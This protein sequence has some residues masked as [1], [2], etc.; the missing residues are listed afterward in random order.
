MVE[1][2][3]EVQ[4][5]IDE[6]VAN[7]QRAQRIYDYGMTWFTEALAHTGN[8][9]QRGEFLP[10]AHQMG[11]QI[12]DMFVADMTARRPAVPVPSTNPKDDETQQD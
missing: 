8:L 11:M 1:I 6:K 9:T 12:R 10:E 7:A 3:E 4:K 2:T 5:I